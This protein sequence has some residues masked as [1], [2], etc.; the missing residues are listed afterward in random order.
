METAS[1]KHS[2]RQKTTS[3]VQQPDLSS[4]AARHRR[5]RYSVDTIHACALQH[6]VLSSLSPFRALAEAA[7]IS[8][9]QDER[10][11][12][13][14]WVHVVGARVCGMSAR[15]LFLTEVGDGI[16]GGG[17]FGLVQQYDSHFERGV[18]VV[19]HGNEVKDRVHS[20]HPL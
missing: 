5:R 8:W 16:F 2:L 3:I 9:I 12:F 7:R 15:I 11:G 17:T 20:E 6:G 13:P 4:G 10:I 19:H 1:N 18:C 14:R